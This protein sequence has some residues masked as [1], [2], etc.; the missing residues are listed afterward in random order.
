MIL[1]FMLTFETPHKS[2]FQGESGGKHPY[3]NESQ[4]VYSSFEMPLR[5]GS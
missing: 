3:R 2:G 1:I 4:P 5:S